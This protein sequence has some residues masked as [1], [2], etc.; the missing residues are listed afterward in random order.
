MRMIERLR[1]AW[2]TGAERLQSLLVRVDL[3]GLVLRARFSR[4]P[5]LGSAPVVLSMTSYGVRLDSVHLTIESIARGLLRPQR[6]LLWL[7]DDAVFRN[8]PAPLRR[9]QARG[10]EVRLSRNFGPHTKYYP[11]VSSQERH[12]LP[13]V[14]AD[15]DLVYPPHWLQGLMAAY[16]SAPQH[17][18]CYRARAI[19]LHAGRLLPYTSWRLVLGTTASHAN[20]VTGVSGAIYPPAFAEHLRVCGDAFMQCCPRQ[21]DIWL[22]TQALR[23]GLRVR[24]VEEKAWQ[25]PTLPDTQHVGL[26]LSN[27]VAGDNDVALAATMQP[28]DLTV[29][30]RDLLTA[31]GGA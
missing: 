8:L 29:I 26:F 18:H 2:W 28:S 12:E 19:G 10:L 11:W 9:L 4:R 6:F 21:D 1:Q 15:D 3:W 30:E 5:V 7:D 27:Q 24:Q 23:T 31:R 20:F 22:T 16:D 13:F 25:L 17:I 14:T